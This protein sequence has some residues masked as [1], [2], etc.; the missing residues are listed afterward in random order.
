MRS[1]ETKRMY[2]RNLRM[3]LNLIPNKIFK[4]YLGESPKSRELEDLSA[5]FTSLA[6]KDINA[7]KQ[8]IK[9]YVKE[10]KKEIEAGRISQS[11]VKNRVKPIRHY[12][13]QM[14]LMFLGQ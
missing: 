11:I 5:S 14:R 7:T 12:F 4:E 13:L 8:I 2:V 6:K 3:F 10:I 9:S 1:S